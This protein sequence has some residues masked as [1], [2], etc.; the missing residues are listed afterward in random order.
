MSLGVSNQATVLTVED[1]HGDAGCYVVNCKTW[2]V[3][4][5][6]GYGEP[7]NASPKY[8]MFKIAD[9]L[10]ATALNKAH[11]G[12]ALRVAKDF[13]FL[14]PEDRSVLD[15]YA[16]GKQQR[17][18]HIELQSIANRVREHANAS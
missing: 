16:T 14:T 5:F 8:T 11:H 3:E 7:F 12:N 15:R 2:E 10:D 4:A 9:E 17:G 13:D 18:D 1:S 6:G